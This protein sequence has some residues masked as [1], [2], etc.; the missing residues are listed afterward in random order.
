MAVDSVGVTIQ[1]YND[2][3][4]VHVGKEVDIVCIPDDFLQIAHSRPG[5][6]HQRYRHALKIT[7]DFDVDLVLFRESDRRT[8]KLSDRFL[9]SRNEDV[10]CIP[11]F[12]FQN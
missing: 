2:L 7:H 8:D 5:F 12:P 3:V 9:A 1:T 10:Y 6:E 4:S 11:R